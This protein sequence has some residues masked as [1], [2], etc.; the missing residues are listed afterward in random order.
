MCRR[1]SVRR[2]AKLIDE[3][4][5]L[6]RRVHAVATFEPGPPGAEDCTLCGGDPCRQCNETCEAGQAADAASDPQGDYDVSV[7]GRR[8]EDPAA[9]LGGGH[10]ARGTFED[11]DALARAEAILE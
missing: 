7:G 5:R 6:K 2:S 9:G 8:I 4:R 1:I 11:N 3:C 10:P